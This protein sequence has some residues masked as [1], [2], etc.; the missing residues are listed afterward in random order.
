[1]SDGLSWPRSLIF[2]ALLREEA[3]TGD[4]GPS[5]NQNSKLKMQ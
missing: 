4:L 1:M 5:E 2:P 3:V